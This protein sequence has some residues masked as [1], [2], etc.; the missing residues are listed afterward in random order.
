VTQRGDGHRAGAT[1]R[2]AA[3][4]GITALVLAGCTSQDA[5]PEAGATTGAP[6]DSATATSPAPQGVALDD[7]MLDD[8]FTAIQFPPGKYGSTTALVES[9][10]PGLAVADDAC[11]APLGL[12]WEQETATTGTAAEFGTSND[13]SMTAVVVSSTAAGTAAGLLS[14]AEEALGAC[15]GPTST[16]TLA[17]AP[18]DLRL[19]RTEP[20]LQGVD[21]ALGWTATGEVGGAPFTLTG[22]T[23]VVGGTA[24]ALV[25]WDPATSA[26]YVPAATQMFVDQTTELAG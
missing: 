4:L 16:F 21:D 6:P 25:G 20:Q 14:Q 18:V 8:M 5:A 2:A 3:A 19:E 22:I 10:Y 24:I 12:G 11:L 1:S 26:T 15:A 9:V 7:A 23:A 17:G 13:R